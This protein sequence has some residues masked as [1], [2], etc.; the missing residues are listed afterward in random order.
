MQNNPL[1]YIC[2]LRI[3]RPSKLRKAVGQ[4]CAHN[5]A[6]AHSVLWLSD[7]TVGGYKGL[8]G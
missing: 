2:G 6:A 1:Y 5:T 8:V 3:G 7:P 4:C